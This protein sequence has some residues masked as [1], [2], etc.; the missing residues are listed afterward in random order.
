MRDTPHH[1]PPRFLHKD[2]PR[3]P[4]S[5]FEHE[6]SADE[7][8]LVANYCSAKAG[9]TLSREQPLRKY[10]KANPS[11]CQLSNDVH[12]GHP[13]SSRWVNCNGETPSEGSPRCH[14]TSERCLNPVS[15]CVCADHL[16]PERPNSTPHSQCLRPNHPRKLL[17]NHAHRNRG[18]EIVKSL[19][20]ARASGH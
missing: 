7:L 11:A 12:Q 2:A 18:Q 16:R 19:R 15:A 10:C 1:L 13:V 20:S 5:I 9:H 6:L 17:R 3:H 8:V 4:W 14:L